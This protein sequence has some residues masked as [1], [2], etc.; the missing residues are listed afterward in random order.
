MAI[1]KLTIQEFLSLAKEHPVLDVRSPGEF[2]HAHIPGATKLPLFS[3]D[4]R[5]IVG[6][7]YKQESKEKEI[8]LGWEYFGVR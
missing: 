7:A 3:D 8:K 4:E 5:K 2:L 6:T 1:N